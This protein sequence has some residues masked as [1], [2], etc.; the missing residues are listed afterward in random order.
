MNTKYSTINKFKVNAVLR[1]FTL[2]LLTPTLS[3]AIGLGDIELKSNLGEKLATKIT[4]NDADTQPDANC[5]TAIDNSDPAAFKKTNIT[6][7]SINGNYQ[8]NIT[9]NEAVTEP[10]VNL[11]IST[12]CEP[13]LSRDYVLL[14]DPV[15]LA[16][17]EKPS[18]P[19]ERNAPDHTKDFTP[20]NISHTKKSQAPL[21]SESA[22]ETSA[23]KPYKISQHKKKKSKKKI[24]TESSVDTKLAEAYIGKDAI[25]TKFVAKPITEADIKARSINEEASANK[26]HLIISGSATSSTG[27]ASMPSLSLRL[28]TQLDLNRSEAESAQPSPEDV[29]DEVTVMRNRLTYMEK[30]ISSLQKQNTLLKSDAEKTKK[31]DLQLQAE[32]ADW[33]QKLP[34]ALGVFASLACIVWLRRKI[35]RKYLLKKHTN[36]F[37][38]KPEE[39]HYHLSEVNALNPDKENLN[40]SLQPHKSTNQPHNNETSDLNKGSL[41]APALSFTFNENDSS[42][43]VLDH[44]EVFIAHNRPAM[45]IQLLQNHL[46]DS[47]VESPEIWLKL[48]NLLSAEGTQ[49]EY[50]NAV[51]ACKQF[52]NV[53][54]PSFADAATDDQSTIED[55][56][57]ILARL[58]EVWGSE[59]AVEFLNDLIFNQQSQP[60]EG[61]GRNTF[62]ELFF[63]KQIA[64]TLHVSNKSNQK[65]HTG[66]S[67][68]NQPTLKTIDFNQSASN[69][70]MAV[71]IEPADDLDIADDTHS[72]QNKLTAES[73]FNAPDATEDDINVFGTENNH[74]NIASASQAPSAT[75][76]LDTL[77]GTPQSQEAKNTLQFQASNQ[78]LNSPTLDLNTT[79]PDEIDLSSTLDEITI[80]PIPEDTLQ[81]TVESGKKS[82]LTNQINTSQYPLI[83]HDSDAAT[84]EIEEKS[85]VKMKTT[86][87]IIEWELPELDK[88]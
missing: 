82:A 56:P 8:L 19:I 18:T 36:W 33:A 37:E 58:Q 12:H 5:F 81:N 43:S 49:T 14:L 79:L 65:T 75:L 60:R 9:T 29:S 77:F 2:L 7:K 16:T 41:F 44:A 11:R 3:F 32:Y 55:Y 6:L 26:P 52:F 57:H 39:E 38:A 10:I 28:D 53:K 74:P 27:A 85:E 17:P 63:L 62:E 20:T 68:T 73:F 78:H 70:G 4:I 40:E 23:E 15:A 51:T 64:T 50:D 59:F 61:F 84:N 25:T 76:E 22:I 88:E 46:V 80:E 66:K 34:I 42:E 1:I 31:A 83:T 86:P 45:A 69:Y 71:N 35:L 47:P 48:I 13:N 54:L 24:I 67:D 30:Q 21:L 72:I 87:L